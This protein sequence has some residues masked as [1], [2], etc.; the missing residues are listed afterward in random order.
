LILILGQAV[1]S[2]WALFKLK[3][4]FK[5]LTAE[6]KSIVQVKDDLINYL[7]LISSL[8]FVAIF[9]GVV[10][11]VVEAIVVKRF[12]TVSIYYFLVECLL[13]IAY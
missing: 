1:I 7:F 6:S 10:L 3:T 11:Y 13:D 9:I 8:I 4:T 5:R 12:E 2:Y